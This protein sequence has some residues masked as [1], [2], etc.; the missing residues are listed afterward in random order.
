MAFTY[1][2]PHPAVTVDALVLTYMDHCIKLLL[3]KRA[4]APFRDCWA[5]PGGF[6]EEN[7]TVEE[8][9]DREL[10]EETGLKNLKLKQ[11]YT[12][13]ALGRDPRG[14]TISVV[15]Y[16]LIS[17]GDVKIS[18]G[19]DAR[20]A[21]WH[22][23]SNLPTLAF[24]HQEIFQKARDMLDSIAFLSIIGYEWFPEPFRQEELLNCYSQLINTEE[25]S[26]LIVD[27]LI[28]Y[29]VLETFEKKFLLRFNH[30][31]LKRVVREGYFQ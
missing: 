5:F 26:K 17:A 29:K 4:D 18:A 16:A 2:Y 14:W 9:V 7:E 13:S 19:S 30:S 21:A 10:E 12:A 31:M 23:I 8:A 11:F 3:I 22:D 28:R 6:V 24:D 25:K 15:F 20:D 1:P 27:R